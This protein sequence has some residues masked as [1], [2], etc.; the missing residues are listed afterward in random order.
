MLP[1]IEGYDVIE[2]VGAG[3]MALVYRARH[4][5]LDRDVALKVLS[6]ER[7]ADPTFTE[8]FMREAQIAAKLVHPNIVQIHDV[9]KSNN[10]LYLSM[11]LIK[12]GSLLDA[13]PRPCDPQSLQP[14]VEQLCSALE[15]AHELGYVH[16][17]IK[18]ANILFRENASLALSDFGISKAISGD[19]NITT[20]G[21]VIG[22]PTYMS[23]EQVQGLNVD[24][25]SDLYSVGVL[26]Y[27]F[28]VGELPYSS[29]SSMSVALKHVSE[30]IP[31]VPS[32]IQRYQ[33]FFD[34][35]LAKAPEDRFESAKE[36]FDCYREL[37]ANSEVLAHESTQSKNASAP[38]IIKSAQA[39]LTVEN[40]SIGNPS[41][42]SDGPNTA[43]RASTNSNA[44]RGFVLLTLAIVSI[45]SLATIISLVPRQEHEQLDKQP[46]AKELSREQKLKIAQL[47]TQAENDLREGKLV[48]PVGE[49]A[50][51]KYLSILNLSVNHPTALEGID[52]VSKALATLIRNY[53]DAGDFDKA[54]LELDKLRVLNS[55]YSEIEVLEM[56]LAIER[57]TA[58]EAKS[59][60]IQN[61][62]EVENT[63]NL[64]LLEKADRALKKGN[65]YQPNNDNAADL[66]Y[67]A[68]KEDPSN[69]LIRENLD[70]IVGI[71]ERD[72]EAALSKGEFTQ[73]QKLISKISVLDTNQ[74]RFFK[75]QYKLNNLKESSVSV[76]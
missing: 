33:M 58:S 38:T 15:H 69:S 30:P 73:A 62:T 17:D 76:K 9:D 8:R 10:H 55:D 5:R 27:Y 6:S 13:L 23:P 48:Y 70:V 49:N 44:K 66:Y 57:A 19:A 71:M 29:E 46:A 20:T 11:E 28:L 68:L 65:I 63:E 43:S 54:R 31:I 60:N 25:R 18:P 14:V 56:S 47:L 42:L 22:T 59:V 12:G 39:A 53:I 52:R 61:T 51:E 67:L 41:S 2:Q 4:K 36:L 3:G 75:L 35:A 24:S 50:Y 45:I 72:T 1:T 32:H 16:R 21:M 64:S 74:D 34:I 40:A 37:S 7:G 26:V